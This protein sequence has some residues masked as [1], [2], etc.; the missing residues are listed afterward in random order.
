[1]KRLKGSVPF[2]YPRFNAGYNCF[3]GY[4]GQ[5]DESPAN[6]LTGNFYGG[7]TADNMFRQSGVDGARIMMRWNKIETSQ[8]IYNWTNIDAVLAEMASIN[9]RVGISI[10]VPS[11]QGST[12][13]LP[14]YIRANNATYGGSAGAGGEITPIQ[15]AGK[16]V[17]W[18][19][20]NLFNRWK[21]FID[22]M[23]ARYKNDAR[24]AYVHI[25]EFVTEIS[26]ADV[27]AASTA[28]GGAATVSAGGLVIRDTQRAYYSYLAAAF[29]PKTTFCQFNYLSGDGSG[30]NVLD[31]IQWAYNV[32]LNFAYEHA[33]PTPYDRA[34]PFQNGSNPTNGGT[35]TFGNISNNVNLAK[36]LGF[37]KMLLTTDVLGS[38]WSAYETWQVG[39]MLRFAA[40]VLEETQESYY[41]IIVENGVNGFSGL[42]REKQQWINMKPLFAERYLRP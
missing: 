28:I 36:S 35:I 37:K 11:F 33:M 42:D 12:S 10:L 2:N 26:D 25:D 18:W 3:L 15:G 9:K 1:M 40:K 38:T 4:A 39:N 22:A 24:L 16:K 41:S 30:Q 32:G 34:Y 5:T 8:G 23:A 20:N 14:D 27:I 19:N 17:I 13:Y 6:L 7:N 29:S 21:A 31:N